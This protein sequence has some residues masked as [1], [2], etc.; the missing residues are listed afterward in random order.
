MLNVKKRVCIW[1]RHHLTETLAL[2]H[3]EFS[4][5]Y[6]FLSN[7]ATVCIYLTTPLANVEYY[8]PTGTDGPIAAKSKKDY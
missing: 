3:Y 7:F 5:K 6:I 8:G 1:V 2:Q 4:A